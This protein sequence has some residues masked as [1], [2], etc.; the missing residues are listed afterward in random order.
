MLY[1]KSAEFIL[2]FSTDKGRAMAGVW[3]LVFIMSGPTKG[4]ALQIE[5]NSREACMTAKQ[6]ISKIYYSN[7]SVREETWCFWKGPR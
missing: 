6:E 2:L 4:A 7:I 5:F 3:I 1:V